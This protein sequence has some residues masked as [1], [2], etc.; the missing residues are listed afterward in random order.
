MEFTRHGLT[1]SLRLRDLVPIQIIVIV[2]LGWT[3]FAAKQGPTQIVLWLLAI[4][5]FYIPLAIV[6]MKLSRALPVE[7]GVYQWVKEGISPFAGYMAAWNLAIYSITAF[8][9]VGSI[10]AEG[11]ARAAGPSAAWMLTSRPVALGLTAFACAIAF[12]FNVR[13]MQFAKWWSNIGSVLTVATFV[14]LLFLLVKAF[15]AKAPLVRGS[16]SLAWPAF[17][18]I[19][20][21]V[22]AKMAVGALSGFDNAA[23]FAEECRK[24][25]ND[26]ARS[27][28]IA[29]PLIALMYILGTSSVL[30]YFD[31]ASV[32]VSAA[33][34]QVM[35]AGFGASAAGKILAVSA[36]TAFNIAYTAAM[37]II[38]GM[39]A[40]LPMVAG[41][42]NLLPSWWSALHPKFRTPHKAIGVV[43][44]CILFLG[45]LSLLGADNQEAVQV[46]ASAGVG[47]LCIMYMLLFAVVLF[48]FR[49][50]AWR[51]GA[52]V[53]FGALCAFVVAFVSLICQIIPVGEVASR[54]IYALKVGA[55]IGATNILGAY[56]YW[57]GD[58]GRNLRKADMEIDAIPGV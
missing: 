1:Q 20:I 12:V 56:V 53:R 49:S 25:E 55:V 7:G 21:S 15:L 41:W 36:V 28:V 39:V 14:A 2:W 44:A 6:V 46:G 22:F 58:R 57:R 29:A 5:L 52:G 34:P 10:L 51:P 26:V 48:S 54:A 8:A 18:L 47:S 43:T 33:V 50:R 23:V 32:D 11:F 17:S 31:P 9:V 4:V 16:F 27:V 35:Q 30:A 19:T 13:G 45:V 38:I 3:G 40:R 37:V 24:P 42:D